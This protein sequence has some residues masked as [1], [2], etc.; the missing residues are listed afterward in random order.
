MANDGLGAAYRRLAVATL[1]Q[2][3]KDA[4]GKGY[5]VEPG[6]RERALAWLQSLEARDLAAALELDEGL[7]RW[8]RT[9]AGK[10]N[11]LARLPAG[12]ES[13]MSESVEELTARLERE[14][15]E[16]ERWRQEALRKVREDLEA[17]RRAREEAEEQERQ[18]HQ[19]EIRAHLEAEA[20]AR[21]LSAWT[22]AGGKAKDFDAEWPAIWRQHLGRKA[23]QGVAPQAGAR[24]FKPHL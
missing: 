5:R 24:V 10:R 12:R 2:A 8:L 18:K 14:R 9:A 6:D 7:Q 1:L 11:K 19:A 17:R 16:A 20:K 21:A 23:A 4:Q 13:E 15:A 3:V 22:A